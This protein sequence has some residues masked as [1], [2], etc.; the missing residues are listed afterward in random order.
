MASSAGVVDTTTGAAGSSVAAG[1]AGTVAQTEEEILGIAT[2]DGTEADDSQAQGDAAAG[3]GDAADQTGS[4][5]QTGQRQQ[6]QLNPDE[7]AA[8][9]PAELKHLLSDPKVAPH[10]QRAFN[11]LADY[12][13]LGTVRDAR[14]FAQEFPGGVREAQEYKN[15]ALDLADWDGQY[16]SG[17]PRQQADLVRSWYDHAAQQGKPEVFRGLVNVALGELKKSDPEGY[18]QL[19]GGTIEQSLGGELVATDG[20]AWNMSGQMAAIRQ[21]LADRNL[22]A[23]E[24]LEQLGGYSYFLVRE[25]EAMG[26]GKKSEGGR[27]PREQER[28]QQR[29]QQQ[30]TR[31]EQLE[32]QTRNLFN[33]TV[34]SD[35][36]TT[37]D[38]S[39]AQTL[40]QQLKDTAFT[41]KGK[42]EI[43]A[44]ILPEI[45][46]R[47]SQDRA[48]VS[49]T[50]Q[51]QAEAKYDVGKRKAVVDYV[52]NR[53]KAL[54]V[55]VAKEIIAAET[56]KFV[57]GTRDA[58]DRRE[59]GA[60]QRVDVT[61]GQAGRT[62]RQLPTRAQIQ[63]MPDSEK[64]AHVEA[65][66][67]LNS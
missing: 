24:K 62:G 21:V 8:G 53:C 48:Y 46:R 26:I 50:K 38:R 59:N 34:N 57:A 2:E 4:A 66:L 14:T 31:Q 41:P 25:L 36:H 30:N 43:S 45:E 18:K 60:R 22:T 55:P 13:K 7:I 5:A 23:D 20:R 19:T 10:L 42:Q 49:R 12:S 9:V 54:V 15:R 17:D 29:E 33:G 3:A 28:F 39:I 58:N 56:E 44:K 61:G 67:G 63:G 1:D 35:V 11:Q 64:D 16:E 47:L 27:I 6:D 32:L 37:M 52:V 51:M 40:A 65:Y